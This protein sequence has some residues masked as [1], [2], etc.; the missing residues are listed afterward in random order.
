MNASTIMRPGAVALVTGASSGIGQ[1]IAEGLLARGLRVICAA[2]R[3]DRLQELYGA[4][5]G[6]ALPISLDV[7]DGDAVAALIQGL[8]ADWREIDIVIANAGSDVGG[9]QR[10][11]EGA[12]SDWAATV[13]TNITGLI[14]V[15]HAV[16]PGMLERR[17]GHVVTIGSIAGLMTYPGG[18]IYAATKHAVRAFT[19]GL[20]KDY[21]NDP[22]RITEILPGMVKYRIRRGPPSRRRREGRGLLRLLPLDHGARGHCRGDS[23][24]PGAA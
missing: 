9:R 8:P 21:S 4:R 14:A 18:S 19:D 2:R 17:R 5:D 7:T 6:Q 3:L 16:I 13:A 23:L 11:D 22:I 15:C 1:S 24:R 10:F 20:R 12:M